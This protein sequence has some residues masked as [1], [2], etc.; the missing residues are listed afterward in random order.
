[1]KLLDKN[2]WL[3]L[4]LG[5]FGFYSVYTLMELLVGRYGPRVVTATTAAAHLSESYFWLISF[6]VGLVAALV[7]VIIF[8]KPRSPLAVGIGVLVGGILG[9]L[10]TL[11]RAIVN[12]DRFFRREGLAAVHY[13]LPH[14]VVLA[15][16]LIALYIAWLSNKMAKS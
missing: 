8:C 12:L 13:L 1:M 2:G 6:I 11:Y 10:P 16:A 5:M 4:V 14:L 9:M 3:N 15:G 7:L